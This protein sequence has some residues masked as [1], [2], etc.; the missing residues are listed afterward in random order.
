MSIK[1]RIL[2][3]DI[4]NAGIKL[5]EFMPG[6][7]GSVELVNF[8]VATPGLAPSDD[9]DRNRFLSLTLRDMMREKL[10]KPG[11]VLLSVSGQTVFSRFVKLP[12]VDKDKILQIVA[13][14]AQQN[15]PFPIEEVVWDYQL[16]GTGVDELDVML[17]AIKGE[18]IETIT[19]AVEG[20][21]LLTDL[22]DVAPMA[23]YNAARYNNADRA[24][25]TL[26][27]DI[28]ARSTDL[29]FLEEHRVFIRSIP[30]AGNTITQQIMREMD[31]PFD[32]AEA[33]KRD[34][35]LVGLS[36]AYEAHDNQVTDQ[37]SK[38]VR[39]VMTRM[40]AE[41]NRSINF[42]RGQQSGSK[43][44]LIL[45]TGGTSVIPGTARFFREKIGVEVD[46]FNPIENV[47]V[48]D[49][50]PEQEITANVQLLGQVVG[51]ALRR[52]LTC[53]I[54]VNLM[55]PKVL[56]D[57]AMRKRRPVFV[58]AGVGLILALL[59][60]CGYFYK[61]TK[62]ADERFAKVNAELTGL[63]SVQNRLSRAQ[64]GVSRIQ[65]QI[66]TLTGLQKKREAWNRVLTEIRTHVPEG[67]WLAT[68]A[69]SA[70]VAAEV[71]AEVGSMDIGRPAGPGESRMTDESGFGPLTV[72]AFDISGLGYLDKVPSGEPVR[73]FRDALIASSLFSDQTRITWQP[74]PAADSITR[75]FQIKAFLEEPLEL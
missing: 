42:Y 20:A 17:V 62:L 8:A 59:V 30:V 57:K 73:A 48:S 7:E 74:T 66:D 71:G 54:E 27:V 46:F 43:P 12:P 61:M 3:L 11:P 16:I 32:Q 35:A 22:V 13:Y 24:H 19:S 69:P 60:W 64:S 36:G 4:G 25:C 49:A 56:A 44:E 51:L 29:I 67:I 50:I 63:R 45:L 15:V 5:A 18:I 40:H 47:A 65:E 23:L 31:V 58:M 53:P 52:V 26:L 38:I 28:G 14:E 37:V 34:H 70:G 6:A 41:I 2:A 75:E 72:A 1:D 33:L 39:S 9:D 10:I 68:I 55:P 21:G